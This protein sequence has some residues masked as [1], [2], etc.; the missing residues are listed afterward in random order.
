M[1][2]DGEPECDPK[3]D[4]S[5]IKE[6]PKPIKKVCKQCTKGM[7][8]DSHGNCG[9]CPFGEFQPNDLRDNEKTEVKCEA[10]PKGTFAETIYDMKEFEKIPEWLDK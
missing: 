10:C 4:Q 5:T 1:D 2:E 6:L 7:H 3:H 8:R 9:Y